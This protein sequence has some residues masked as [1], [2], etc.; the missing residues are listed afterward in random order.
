MSASPETV[1]LR[2]VEDG[3]IDVFF[4]HQA[5]PE[6]SRMAGFPARERRPFVVQWARIRP[7]PAIVTRTIVADGQVAGNIASWEESGKRKIGYWVG[8]Q[9]WGHGI[10]TRALALF[11]AEINQRP[12]YAHVVTHNIA[13]M[14]VLEKCGFRQVALNEPGYVSSGLDLGEE[15]TFVLER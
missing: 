3:D 7:N 15:A 5:D 10:A 14:R 2:A 12:L 9:Y 6:A 4:E 8:R 11:L 13:S 1:S